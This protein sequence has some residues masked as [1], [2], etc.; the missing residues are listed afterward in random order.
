MWNF[1]NF[2]N[3]PGKYAEKSSGF[4]RPIY[5]VPKPFRI[6][7]IF[8]CPWNGWKPIRNRWFLVSCAHAP[9]VAAL[10]VLA[11][12]RGESRVSICK[13]WCSSQCLSPLASSNLIHRFYCTC[14]LFVRFLNASNVFLVFN[15]TI[16]K[17]PSLKLLTPFYV[18][19]F[20]PGTVL[21]DQIHQ[22][23]AAIWSQ[24]SQECILPLRPPWSSLQC[25][26]IHNQRC[27]VSG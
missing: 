16:L 12:K 20:G 21:S 9:L 24:R 15:R 4:I 1:H 6:N 26:F 14:Q 11:Q 17:L 5:T 7:I 3:N 25:P 19:V 8:Y 27:Q 23:Q 18:L 10:H 2:S 22:L 13:N